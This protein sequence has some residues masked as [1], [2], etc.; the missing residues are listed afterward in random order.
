M[1]IFGVQLLLITICII[2]LYAAGYNNKSDFPYIYIG[3]DDGVKSELPL[4]LEQFFVFF[5]L[6]SN[7]IPISLHV[8]L[9]LVQV[10]QSY[11]LGNDVDM[12]DDEHKSGALVKSSN[13]LQ[14]FG[15]VT[16]I[17]SDKTGTCHVC[18]YRRPPLTTLVLTICPP[19]LEFCRY[20][21]EE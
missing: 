13:L 10:A 2:G 15:N 1:V 8:T 3:G 9:V 16:N 14:E 19:S 17:F 11:L 18:H 21:D 5:L 12:Y 20:F 7:V 6:F 4:W